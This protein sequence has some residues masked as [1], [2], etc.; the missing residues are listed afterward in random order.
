M[1]KPLWHCPKCG[2]G[3]V[4]RNL[5]HSCVRVPLRAHFKGKPPERKK[6]YD[7]WL[8]AARAA[9]SVTAYAQKSRIIFMRTVRFGG[10]TVHQGHIN[11]SLWLRR[12]I[13]HPLLKKT[14]D[15]GTLGFGHT[16][17]LEHPSDVDARLRA[18]IKEAYR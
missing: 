11:A 8:A 3:F 12:R 17:R 7:A 15:F 1:T 14:Q 10:C 6:T 9:G 18:W 5:W 2:H 16:F 4:T 13:E